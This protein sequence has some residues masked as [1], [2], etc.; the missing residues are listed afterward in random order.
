MKRAALLCAV[1]LTAAGVTSAGP[2]AELRHAAAVAEA[3]HRG[4]ISFQII[5]DTHARGGPFKQTFHYRSAY[6]YEG[7]R[8]VGARAL[9][10][11]DNGHKSGQPEL[12][13]ETKR[14]LSQSE[15]A[16]PTG[17]AVPFDSRHFDEYRF[18]RAACDTGCLD[19][20]T[21]ITFTAALEDANHGDGRMIIDRD[22]HVRHLEYS[23]GV[24]PA[25]GNIHAKE[26][27]VGIDRAAVLPGFWATT[28][29]E[30]RFS[31]RYGFITGEARQTAR[32]E[33][34]RRFLSVAEALS[35]LRSTVI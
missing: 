17:F 30:S 33:R 5:W 1:L 16:G 22:G 10:K 29:I 11:I 9:E 3:D 20:D 23:P 28:K 8:L 13:A 19:G 31:G 25:F 21:T 7:N 34:Y 32:Y 24:K 12:D 27:L 4:I 26:A 15:T 35:A 2:P 6:V 14:I 18:A